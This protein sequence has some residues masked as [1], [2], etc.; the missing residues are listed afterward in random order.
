MRKRVD[1]LVEALELPKDLCLG[2]AVITVVGSME[3][4]VENH[5]GLLEY[6]PDCLRILSGMCRIRISGE[7]LVISYFERDAMKIKGRIREI[8]YE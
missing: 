6:S 2:A 1:A 5:R 7:H 4:T 8:S 3:M